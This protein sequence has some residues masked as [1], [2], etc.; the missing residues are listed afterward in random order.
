MEKKKKETKV[1]SK[2]TT[3]KMKVTSKEPQ[4]KKAV[5]KK[6]KFTAFTLIELLAVIIILGVLMIIA[7]PAVTNYISNSRKSAYV[8]TAKDLMNGAR[9]KVNEGTLDIYD[10]GKTYYLPFSIVKTENASKSPYGEFREA[11]IVITYNGEGFDYYWTSTDETNTGIYLTYYDELE[12]DKIVSNVN[13]ELTDVAICDKENIVIFN[14]DGSIKEEKEASDCIEQKGS[15]EM[16]LKSDPTNASFFDFDEETGTIE[17][18]HNNM[19]LSLLDENAC[20]N[21]FYDEF[22][23]YDSIDEALDYCNT[24]LIDIIVYNDDVE[25]AEELQEQNIIKINSLERYPKN[26]VIP[27]KIDGVEVVAIG[28]D[29][30]ERV[31]AYSIEVPK[32]V[33]T[34]DIKAFDAESKLYN[35][36]NKT[37]K[38]FVWVYDYNDNNNA[39]KTGDVYDNRNY[40]NSLIK[41]T[42]SPMEII[43]IDNMFEITNNGITVKLKDKKG[44]DIYYYPDSDNANRKEIMNINESL[45]APECKCIYVRIE[46]NGELLYQKPLAN[47]VCYR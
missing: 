3:S 23:W 26:I 29:A 13:S 24:Q 19:S 35:I 43:D 5:K 32:S 14:E 25:L 16:E 46:K 28:R 11:Y 4:K 37:G 27:S 38:A 33:T 12:N 8:A 44:Y 15:Y 6:K 20:A 36:I 9:T 45:T 30:F 40:V 7:V 1:A 18:I 22:G 39:I 41:V 31:N 2:K 34:I 21:Y 17:G 42:T 10:T 47:Y